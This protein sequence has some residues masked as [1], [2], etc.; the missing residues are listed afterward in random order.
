MRKL[1]QQLA[2]PEGAR[3]DIDPTE[4]LEE[5]DRPTQ[6][7]GDNGPVEVEDEWGN[8]GQQDE[9]QEDEDQ[10]DEDDGSREAREIAAHDDRCARFARINAGEAL[11]QPQRRLIAARSKVLPDL[12]EACLKTIRRF[13]SDLLD[14]GAKA[15]CD[16]L[17][18][19][20]LLADALRS[21]LDA[22]IAF[23]PDG[24]EGT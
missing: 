24:W 21:K 9:D 23:A 19:Q 17:L 13:A 7:P 11:T 3:D 1:L 12:L 4:V 5:E 2:R 18:V 16:D 20:M 6:E 8:E 15:G 22:T 10:H 14:T